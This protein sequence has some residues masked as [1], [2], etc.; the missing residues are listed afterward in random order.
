MD[1]ELD[2]LFN[3]PALL[4]QFLAD[5]RRIPLI[6]NAFYLYDTKGL[7]LEVMIE[8]TRL[9]AAINGDGISVGLPNFVVDAVK[10]GWTFEKAILVVREALVD[11]DGPN[12][13]KKAADLVEQ[14]CRIIIAKGALTFDG[15]EV[16]ELYGR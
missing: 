7:P 6:R 16:E 9:T 11:V 5:A 8:H 10:A 2:K 14:F 4:I 1:P 15:R 13:G 3:N 12:D